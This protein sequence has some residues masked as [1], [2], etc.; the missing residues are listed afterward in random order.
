MADRDSGPEKHPVANPSINPMPSGGAPDSTP[1][2]RLPNGAAWGKPW[3]APRCTAH[4]KRTGEPCRQPAMSGRR[5]CRLH[6]GKSPGAPRGKRHGR[7]LHRMRT[8][9]TQAEFA[10]L[11]LAC[12]RSR[13]LKRYRDDLRLGREAI[14]PAP[15]P[16]E[17][18]PPWAP[19]AR[20]LQHRRRRVEAERALPEHRA[21]QVEREHHVR[22]RGMGVAE[23]PLHLRGLIDAAGAGDVH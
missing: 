16:R 17:A 3:L 21:L 20:R 23:Q 14:P 13:A 4:S 9:Q 18:I 10:W 22:R 19:A 15:L 12:Q 6:G 8:K 5:V 7:Y 11:R 1:L 2:R